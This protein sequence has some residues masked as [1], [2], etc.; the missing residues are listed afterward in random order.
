M[1]KPLSDGSFTKNPASWNSSRKPSN[2][3][4]MFSAMKSENF[5]LY[6]SVQLATA[7]ASTSA[8][9]CDASNC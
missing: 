8:T 2:C 6:T 5:D 9:D 3:R 7:V 4:T 1:H